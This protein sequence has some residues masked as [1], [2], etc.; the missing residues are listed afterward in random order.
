MGFNGIPMGSIRFPQSD[1]IK[2]NENPMKISWTSNENQWDLM[3][4]QWDPFDF[5]NQIQWKSREN[6]MHI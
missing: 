2:S 5:P 3:E 1:P 6:F 4:F